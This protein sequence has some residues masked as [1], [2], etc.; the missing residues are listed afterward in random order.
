MRAKDCRGTWEIPQSPSKPNEVIS[1]W[2]TQV[3]PELRAQYRGVERRLSI[4][5]SLSSSS[6]CREAAG[7]GRLSWQRQA[8]AARLKTRDGM[9]ICRREASW[10]T[11]LLAPG[12]VLSMQFLED[13]QI[14]E[15]YSEHGL[16]HS[17]VAVGAVVMKLF[18][19]QSVEPPGQESEIAAAAVEALGPWEECLL[20]IKLW[21]IWPSSEDWPKYYAERGAQGER[22]S[23][24]IA[25]GHLFI[26]DEQRL[27]LRFLQVVL[28]NAWEAEAYPITGGILN[29]RRLFVSHDE[30]IE[31]TSFRSWRQLSN[32]P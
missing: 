27:L 32:L 12:R 28:E 29:G 19:G 6:G 17:N 5:G 22:R 13:N 16:T 18:F 11:S 25:P 2:M 3:R 1:V 9:L 31:I 14:A 21:S 24:E 7:T 23:L 10:S 26:A 30:F 20:W 8:H 4:F 15:W